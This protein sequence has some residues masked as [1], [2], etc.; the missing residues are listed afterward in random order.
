ML[1]LVVELCVLGS[2]T[3]HKKLWKSG[4]V[5]AVFAGAFAANG[6]LSLGRIKNVSAWPVPPCATQPDSAPVTQLSVRAL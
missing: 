3:R 6:G 4:S 1:K 5:A 2:V